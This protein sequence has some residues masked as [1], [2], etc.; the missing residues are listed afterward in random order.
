MVTK[1]V[2]K[3]YYVY[4]AR[5]KGEVIYV[6]MGRLDRLDHV[7][8][9]ASH[10]ADINK[11]HFLHGGINVIKE[12][13]HLTEAEALKEEARLINMYIPICNKQGSPLGK[14]K[15][16]CTRRYSVAAVEAFYLGIHQYL[17]DKS[18]RS[19]H[20]NSV[21]LKEVAWL[22]VQAGAGTKG[23]PERE[24][25]ILAPHVKRKLKEAFPKEPSDWSFL[26]GV[27]TVNKEYPNTSGM[28]FTIT[29]TYQEWHKDWYNK[30]FNIADMSIVSSILIDKTGYTVL[31]HAVK[32]TKQ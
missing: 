21:V 3:D 7:T 27:I 19:I 16:N 32:C 24:F 12:I 20:K 4:A 22:L 13:E 2:Y 26:D 6:G 30:C 23:L 28:Y 5:I 25:C 8:S 10:N 29:E 18:P 9:G 31:N 11:L 14:Y 17:L 1:K 15:Y